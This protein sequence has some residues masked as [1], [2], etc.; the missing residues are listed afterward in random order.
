MPELETK[1]IDVQDGENT[2]T[3]LMTKMDCLAASDWK[4]R[5]GVM[6][7]KAGVRYSGG[8]KTPTADEIITDALEKKEGEEFFLQL[9]SLQIEDIQT[10]LTR[11]ILTCQIVRE[12]SK[13][14]KTVHLNMTEQNIR[15]NIRTAECLWKIRWEAIRYNFG[16]FEKG[17]SSILNRL[18]ASFGSP[19]IE[20][21]IPSS[22]S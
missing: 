12:D 8:K 9:P 20:T 10:L 7:A 16:F 6:V 14:G 13:T 5:L 3:I 2:L 17:G 21:S 1:T 4:I 19:N 18:K 15:A 22:A 11:M